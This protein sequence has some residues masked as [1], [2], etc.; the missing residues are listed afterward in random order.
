MDVAVV[1]Q[2]ARDLVLVVDEV[3]GP[4]GSADVR[5]RREMLGGKG[6]NQAVSLAQLGVRPGLVGVVGDDEVGARLLDQARRDRID[7]SHVV[8]REGAETGLIVDVVDGSG[9]WHYLED[10]PEPVLLTEADVIAAEPMLREAAWVSVQLQQ[11]SDAVHAALGCAGD[12]RIVLDGAP[13]E[14]D[15]DALLAAAHL[16]R[17]DAREAEMLAGTG[18][19]AETAVRLGEDLVRRGPSLVALAVES[20]NVFA[21]P[22]GHLVLPLDDVPVADTTGAGDALTAALIAALTRGDPPERAARLA[23][24]AAGATVGHPGGRPDLD[25][26]RLRRRAG[27]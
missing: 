1:G 23:V 12:A 5:R 16:V 14:D 4:G 13:A 17:A 20:A 27:V 3:P 8:R 9:R 24:A 19:D 18:L 11:P 25:L 15:R 10:L 22:D 21:W 7:V 2:I 6:A 26:D